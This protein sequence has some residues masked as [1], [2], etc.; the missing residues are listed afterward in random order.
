[1]QQSSL[2]SAYEDSVYTV[3]ISL[4]RQYMHSSTRKKINLL[5]GMEAEILAKSRSKRLV[6]FFTDAFNKFFDPVSRVR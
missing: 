2:E 6:Q 1:V 5:P 3:Y 4:S